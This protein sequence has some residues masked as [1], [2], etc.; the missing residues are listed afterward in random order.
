VSSIE[1][2]ATTAPAT[3]RRALGRWDLTAIGV[4]QVIGG[5]V[6]LMPSQVARAVGAWSILFVVLTGLSTLF[7]ALCFAE[8]GSRFERTGGAYIYTR[9][10]FGRFVGFEVGWMQWFTRV[11]SQASVVNGIAL[12]LAFYWSSAAH[13]LPRAAMITLLTCAL[14]VLNVAGIRQ[15]AWVVNALTIAKLAPLLGFVVAGIWYADPGVAPKSPPLGIDNVASAALLLTFTFGGFDVIG[16]PAGEAISP[17]RH[18]PFALI[19]TIATVTI[20]F[21]LAQIVLVGVLP[22]LANASTPIADAARKLFGPAA[23]LAVGVGAILSMTGNNAGQV[24]S[25]SRMLFALAEQG[26]LPPSLGRVHPRYRTPANAIVLTTIAALV[27][28]LSGSFAKLAAVSA[29]A[30]LI[31]YAGTAAA[32][33]RLR[34]LEREGR[35]EPAEYTIPFGPVIP[36]LA[37]LISILILIGATGDQLAA[38]VAALL[39][40]G[41]LFVAGRRSVH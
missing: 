2:P 20:L 35:A 10:A 18:V 11:T 39:V 12:A 16:V 3:L 41:A 22:D 25:G 33:L 31:A 19:A 6:F 7:V 1:T 24:L 14:A 5:A 15:S 34:Q 36:V 8:A 40:G 38:G 26:D 32:A 37:L 28:A 13:G 30:R 9:A 4:N 23:A 21:T 27:L 17:R 29:V